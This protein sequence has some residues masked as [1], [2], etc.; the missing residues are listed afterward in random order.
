MDIGQIRAG[1]FQGILPVVCHRYLFREPLPVI[2]LP[3]AS[4]GLIILIIRQ[5][6]YPAFACRV[7]PAGQPYALHAVP[8]LR[9]VGHEYH[10]EGVG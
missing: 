5:G 8:H 1:G 10:K 9:L 6:H 2:A 3:P 7:L 4:P